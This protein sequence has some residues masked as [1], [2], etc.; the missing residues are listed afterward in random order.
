MRALHID[1]AARTVTEVE[2]PEPRAVDHARLRELQRLVGGL[3]AYAWTFPNGDT[4][5]V[6][7]EGLLK[8]PEHFFRVCGCPQEFFAG[9]GV[10]VGKA[11]RAGYDTAAVS[12]TDELRALLRFASVASRENPDV[13]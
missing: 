1:A 7:D 9:N 10:V 5:F 2:T 4:L 6:D 3:I 11:T 8:Q 13:R 12:T